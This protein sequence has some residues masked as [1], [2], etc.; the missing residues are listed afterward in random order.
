MTSDM[1]FIAPFP[2]LFLQYQ[3]FP[4]QCPL[5]QQH[6]E[7]RTYE[8]EEGLC[9]T[10][11]GQLDQLPMSQHVEGEHFFFFQFCYFTFHL[12]LFTYPVY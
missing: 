11:S 6:T 5:R 3:D 12:G 8:V 9:T 2:F 4:A 1:V 10:H 7:E